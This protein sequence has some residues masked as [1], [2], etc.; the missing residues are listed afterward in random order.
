MD[1]VGS[2]PVWEELK[3]WSVARRRAVGTVE[4]EGVD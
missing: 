3:E 1:D 2:V 4:R